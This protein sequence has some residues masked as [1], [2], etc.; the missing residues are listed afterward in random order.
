MILDVKW[1]TEPVQLV[2]T[3]LTYNS[4]Y[5]RICIEDAKEIHCQKK[6]PNEEQSRMKFN[7]WSIQLHLFSPCPFKNIYD[8][9]DKICNQKSVIISLSENSFLREKI[10]KFRCYNF[11]LVM[12][13]QTDQLTDTRRRPYLPN[14]ASPISGYVTIPS[15]LSK[16]HLIRVAV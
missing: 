3:I 11:S 9:P 4:V 1:T 14:A 6:F 2:S 12:S 10:C 8:E 15:L 5:R 7:S 16:Q 13:L